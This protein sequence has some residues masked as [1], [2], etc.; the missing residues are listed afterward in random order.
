MIVGGILNVLHLLVHL[1]PVDPSDTTM[2]F[3]L[4]LLT[5]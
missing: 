1:I 4:I 5:L 2:R 3:G